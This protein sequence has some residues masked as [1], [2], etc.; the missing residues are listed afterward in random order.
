M[1]V[2][3]YYIFLFTDG[4][5]AEPV[6]TSQCRF[7]VLWGQDADKEDCNMI[8]RI[9]YLFNTINEIKQHN[10]EINSLLFKKKSRL[11]AKYINYLGQVYQDISRLIL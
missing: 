6:R 2:L 3:I 8:I 4:N 10:F 1:T 11:L 9:I 7:L 5:A